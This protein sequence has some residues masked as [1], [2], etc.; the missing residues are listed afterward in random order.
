MT[1]LV[2]YARLVGGCVVAGGQGGVV[3]EGF[4]KV[5]D[6]V[7]LVSLATLMLTAEGWMPRP[8]MAAPVVSD[9]GP[10]VGIVTFF[11]C[12]AGTAFEVS[13]VE[14]GAILQT[15]T[16]GGSVVIHLPEPG[17]YRI[18]AQPPLP[19]LPLQAAVD[20]AKSTAHPTPEMPGVRPGDDNS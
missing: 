13:D 11:D 9:A 8:A 17:R 6:E 3:P 5:P 4:V 18:D 10:G 19:F 2:K 12:P 14:T 1:R 15:I 7:D 16:A 20:V